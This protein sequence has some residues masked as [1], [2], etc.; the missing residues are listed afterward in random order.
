MGNKNV[1]VKQIEPYPVHLPKDFQY[2]LENNL[3]INI[4]K[5]VENIDWA[6]LAERE[7]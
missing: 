5:K 3:E 7:D 4:F 1:S 6:I 2:L